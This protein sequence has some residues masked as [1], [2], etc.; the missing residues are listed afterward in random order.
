VR[1]CGLSLCMSEKYT[2]R[3][4]LRMTAP[5]TPKQLS[6]DVAAIPASEWIRRLRSQILSADNVAQIVRSPR[7]GFDRDGMAAILKAPDQVFHIFM[8][9]P[10]SEDGG[11]PSFEIT[12][13][14]P[15]KEVARKL[16]MELVAEMQ[17]HWFG[18]QTLIDQQ[19]DEQL[20][21]AHQHHAGEKFVIVTSPNLDDEAATH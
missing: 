19:A 10:T 14:H 5:F 16:A 8:L 1:C 17:A 7:F 6:G 21:F 11:V 20:R 4:V 3:A 9:D 13:A 18:L 15:D 2:A 12:V